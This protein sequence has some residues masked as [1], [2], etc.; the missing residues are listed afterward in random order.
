[1]QAVIEV[2]KQFGPQ[3]IERKLLAGHEWAVAILHADAMNANRKGHPGDNEAGTDGNRA[4]KRRKI[5]QDS[6]SRG[7]GRKKHIGDQR[8]SDSMGLKNTGEYVSFT[9]NIRPLGVAL[10]SAY[11]RGRPSR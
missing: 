9:N 6:V 11:A 7:R 4:P 2:L 8:Q 3:Q 1:M 5:E 10:R